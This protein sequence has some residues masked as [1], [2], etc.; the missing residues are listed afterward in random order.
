MMPTYF[1][2]KLLKYKILV[3][4][5]PFASDLQADQNAEY[6]ANIHCLPVGCSSSEQYTNTI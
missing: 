1:L 5:V 3:C 2:F 4:C 6:Q